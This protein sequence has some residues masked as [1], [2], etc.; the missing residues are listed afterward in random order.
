MSRN[1]TPK[2]AR[3][4]LFILAFL[5]CCVMESVGLGRTTPAITLSCSE[6]N[7]LY[8]VLNKSGLKPKRFETPSRA[9]ADASKG[10]TVLLLA[11]DYPRRPLA[12]SPQIFDEAA[13]KHLR[14]Y[15]EFAEFVPNVTL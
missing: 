6:N 9:I 8:L 5:L 3:V 15:V 14:L 11:D 4:S 12:L 1:C 2:L 7:D 13:A 10:S